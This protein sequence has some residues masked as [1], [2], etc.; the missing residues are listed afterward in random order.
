[1]GLGN[2]VLRARISNSSI[3][4]LNSSFSCSNS[5][6]LL[7]SSSYYYVNSSLRL[8]TGEFLPFCIDFVRFVSNKLPP[9]AGTNSP[10]LSPYSLILYFPFRFYQ[11]FSRME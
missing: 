5:S 9:A 2:W 1:M 3:C 7:V 6:L 11:E 8:I 10:P 4:L